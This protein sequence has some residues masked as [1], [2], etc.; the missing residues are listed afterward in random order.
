MAI[1]RVRLGCDALFRE[2]LA[3]VH[4]KELKL[5]HFERG[6]AKSY[7]GGSLRQA[8]GVQVGRNRLGEMLMELA[9]EAA[10]AGAT[11]AAG[12]GG[13]RGGG[14]AAVNADHKGDT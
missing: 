11:T 8:D 3:A 4:E 14:G 2:I 9:A 7:W 1:L 13:A 5:L 10:V 12:G 6:G